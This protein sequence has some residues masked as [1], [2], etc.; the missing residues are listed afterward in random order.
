MKDNLLHCNAF[1]NVQLRT[2]HDS[3]HL[4]LQVCV[5]NFPLLS[6]G[7]SLT[8]RN[9]CI[10]ACNNRSYFMSFPSIYEDSSFFKN[11]ICSMHIDLTPTLYRATLGEGKLRKLS[12]NASSALVGG[13]G[14]CTSSTIADYS[15][16]SKT[17]SPSCC[18]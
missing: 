12:H 14:V 18:S 15:S 2:P 7:T 13:T 11:N 5:L 9:I 16:N 6:T 1:L 3:F 4:L 17:L 10:H 8:F